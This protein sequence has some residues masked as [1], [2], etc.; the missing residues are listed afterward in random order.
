MKER[1]GEVEGRWFRKGG[2]ERGRGRL[3][4]ER[5]KGKCEEGGGRKL[6]EERE[7]AR[8]RRGVGS[9]KSKKMRR[10]TGE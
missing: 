6:R 5:K 2:M 1:G 9:G 10:G 3:L 8:K 4:K 7:W